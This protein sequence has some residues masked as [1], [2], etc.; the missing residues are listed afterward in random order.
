MTFNQ[1]AIETLLSDVASGVMSLGMFQ[2]VL[3]HE[4]KSKPQHDMTFAFFVD[5]IKPSRLISGV[6]A[7]A[8]MVTLMGR[9]YVSFLTKPEDDV[10]AQLL[11]GVSAIIDGL[12]GSFTLG[13]SVVAVD[14]I[15]MDSSGLSAQ[16]GYTTVDST[17][18]RICDLTIPV[19]IDNLWTQAA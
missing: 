5:S 2:E 12:T 16:M 10:D 1:A 18:F 13:H 9:A 8:G 14:L 4:P 19:L 3:R 17:V 11:N 7:T 15:G 6:D